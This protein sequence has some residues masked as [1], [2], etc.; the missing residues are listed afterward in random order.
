[1]QSRVLTGKF[2]ASL[3]HER[4]WKASEAAVDVETDTARCGKLG[5]VLDGI[6]GSVGELGMLRRK[7]PAHK[8]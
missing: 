2:K 5:K 7:H 6:D 4:H 1:M 3:A 8:R